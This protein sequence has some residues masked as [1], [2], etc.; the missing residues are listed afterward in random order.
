MRKTGYAQPVVFYHGTFG[1]TKR[2]A[3]AASARGWG[4][5]RGGAADRTNATVACRASRL[6]DP[7]RDRRTV[8]TRSLTYGK[9]SGSARDRRL[10]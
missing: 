7:S 10:S 2:T 4:F 3:L 5:R 1:S 9:I 6:I 8:F